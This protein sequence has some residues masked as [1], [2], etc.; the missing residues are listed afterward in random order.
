[1]QHCTAFPS[2]R[3]TLLSPNNNHHVVRPNAL[4]RTWLTGQK[5]VIL[6]LLEPDLS[7]CYT[8]ML[9]ISWSLGSSYENGM[10]RDF[11][12]AGWLDMQQ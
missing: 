4:S 2:F 5:A 10:I 9:Q 3:D 6:N 11:G 12:L 8:Q 7:V 1:V